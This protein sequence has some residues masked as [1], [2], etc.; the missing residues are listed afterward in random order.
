MNEQEIQNFKNN[1]E[2]YLLSDL[3]K[4]FEADNNPQIC[5][6]KYSTGFT[7]LDKALAGGFS[8]GLHCIGAVPSLGKSTFVLQMAENFAKSGKH[9]ILF[10]LEMDAYSIAAK[11]ES[12]HLKL[13][14]DYNV[15]SADFFVPPEDEMLASKRFEATKII[16]QKHHDTFR[17]LAILD[18]SSNILTVDAICEYVNNY[19]AAY[20]TTP[21]VIIDYLQFLSTPDKLKNKSERDII[22]YNITKLKTL[23]IVS[24]VIL[25]SS[26]N[27]SSYNKTVDFV[28]FKE[29]GDI[30]YT[31]DTLIGIELC[32]PKDETGKK[33]KCD[34]TK[35]KAKYPRK[36]ELVILKQR[37][38][39][40][41][42]IISYD[43][44]TKYNYFV[45][46]SSIMT[47]NF[48]IGP[49]EY[50]NIL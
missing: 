23:S 34:T 11:N 49:D 24:P 36:I 14:N 7:E 38:G 46:T 27:R 8:A 43:F 45:E 18:S 32:I 15:T 10:S 1:H 39:E 20:Q 4:M 21:I 31:C 9:C 44:Y 26:F 6:P 28:S 19:K 47:S 25:I 50:N 30:E 42:T 40:V 2:K 16:N 29:S 35:L 33:L 48:E 37:Y 13:E 5:R 17:N 22:N 41:G 3:C 12:K